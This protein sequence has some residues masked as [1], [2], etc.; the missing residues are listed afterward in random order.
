MKFFPALFVYLLNNRTQRRNLMILVRLLVVLLVLINIYSVTFHLLMARE[1]QDFSW[2]TGYYWTLTVMST[3][4]FG[5]ITFHTDVGRMFSMLVLA[6]GMVFLLVLL[7]FTFI[8]FFYAPWMEAQHAAAT[9][10]KL[11]PDTQGHVVLTHWDNVTA[12][13]IKKLPAYGYEY[14]L[15]IPTLEEARELNELG[16][17]VVLGELDDPETYHSVRFAQA[18]MLATTGTDTSNT[19]TAF[20]A[21]EV[22]S[23]V[24]VVSTAS[25]E[26]SIEVLQLSG[27]DHVVHL[28]EMLG[29]SLARRCNAGKK[30]ANLLGRFDELAVAEAP[31]SG[32]ELVGK[33][34]AESRLRVETGVSAIGVWERGNF[35]PAAADTR[36][37]ANTV[38]VLAGSDEHLDAFNQRY[39]RPSKSAPVVIVGGGRV[40]RAAGRSLAKRGL[41]YR[42]IEQISDRIRDPKNYVLGDAFKRETLEEAG[43][44]DAPAVILTTH[45]D[46]TNV[47]L[48]I[49]I[50]RIRSDIQLIGRANLERNISSLHR[51]GADFVMSYASMGASAILNV[52]RD[53]RLLMVAEGLGLFKVVLPKGLIGKSLIESNVRASTGCS[54]VGVRRKDFTV[55]NPQPD[56]IFQENDELVIIGSV[57]AEE[58]FLELYPPAKQLSNGNSVKPESA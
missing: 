52:L 44:A 31:V 9:P 53:D 35:K 15:I 33:T 50:R 11:P 25:R 55:V 5:D 26:A 32:T 29:Q 47:Y 38:L 2:L 10:R 27:V 16:I 48:A 1:G 37:T 30:V 21:S 8:E 43:I 34:L 24:R 57:E 46:D 3:L 36:I 56:S 19:N 13:L 22:A 39:G 6:T 45:D 17:R 14:V 28:P 54:I 4:G 58:K 51:A 49:F 18:A 41:E 42:I 23:A 40:G 12:N 20:T 7:P